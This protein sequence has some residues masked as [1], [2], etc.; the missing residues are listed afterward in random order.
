MSVKQKLW[1]CLITFEIPFGSM[2]VTWPRSPDHLTQLKSEV[3]FTDKIENSKLMAHYQTNRFWPWCWFTSNWD[4]KKMVYS[5][6]T[7]SHDSWWVIKTHRVGISMFYVPQK[8]TARLMS[9]SGTV[10]RNHFI[11]ERTS[12]SFSTRHN[13]FRREKKWLFY[14]SVSVYHPIDFKPISCIL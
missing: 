3:V 6:W 5:Y 13:L 14:H 8:K 7:Q 4:I 9:F 10:H 11:S 12:I 2:F 1:T